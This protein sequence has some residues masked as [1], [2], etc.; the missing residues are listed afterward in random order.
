[1]LE[2][3]KGFKKLTDCLNDT[4]PE[5]PESGIEPDPLEEYEP[6]EPPEIVQDF[7]EIEPDMPVHEA[8]HVSDEN[9]VNENVPE[10]LK[11]VFVHVE[12]INANDLR[13]KDFSP[14][15]WAVEGFL[16]SGLSILAG[17][18]KVGKSILSLHLSLA[19]AIG[20]CAL[21]KINV[22]Q[23]DVLYLALEDTQRRL[24]ERI[25]GSDIPEDEDLSRLTLATRVPRQHEGGLAYIRWWLEGHDSA[26]L[27]IIDTLQKFR[28]QLSG[29]GNIYAEDY[30][31]VSEIK[32]LADEYDVPILVIH[33]LKKAMAE[34]WLNEISGSQGI[35]GAADTL[36]ALKRTRTENEGVLHRT[37]RD[38]EEKDFD[39]TLDGFRWILVG[40]QGLFTLPK[41]KRD[42][43]QYLKE[44]ETVTPAELGEALKISE[45]TAQT[46]LRR[47]YKD[48]GLERISRG[49]YRLL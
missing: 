46:N 3:E 29:K 38:V 12:Q 44:H 27:V 31:T 36:F 4:T 6:V 13:H 10:R 16:P 7:G 43:A 28:K 24:Q 15:K 35:A 5:T 45:K 34:D 22:E 18:P 26:R 9:R 42:I 17:G 32:K 39:M 25:L 19:V 14:L 23:G 8:G 40:D 48:G 33:H 49:T 2:D 1:M 21:G 37:G 30:D 11:K 20:G 47:F 41:W